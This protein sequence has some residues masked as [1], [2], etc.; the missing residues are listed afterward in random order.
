MQN[1]TTLLLINIQKGFS[2]PLW[3]K[4]NNPQAEQNMTKLLALFRSRSQPIFHV[5][6][7]S[8]NSSSPLNPQHSG[9]QFMEF[10]K[11]MPNE[12]IFQKQVNSAFIGTNLEKELRQADISKLVIVGI[13]T[14]HCVSTTARM[15]ANLG[16]ETFIVA[17]ATIAFE[18][19][20][21]DG[22]LYSAE[23]VHALALASLHG[24]F[25]TVLNTT[26]L[27]SRLEK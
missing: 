13:S 9:V 4:R 14:D 22:T 24:E 23:T 2:Y 3:E 12:P 5:Q 16:F 7:L 20:G 15:A 1:G 10:S 19:V 18:R 11:P 6:H 8:R 27:I 21:F 25:A 26:D 17:D